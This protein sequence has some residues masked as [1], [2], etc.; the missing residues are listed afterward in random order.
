MVPI[1]LVHKKSPHHNSYLRNC[2]KFQR[3]NDWLNDNEID[4]YEYGISAVG[5]KKSKIVVDFYFV[6]FFCNVTNFKE[7]SCFLQPLP[8]QEISFVVC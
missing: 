3:I 7:L 1:N 6:A 4:E 8:F 5:L 2:L